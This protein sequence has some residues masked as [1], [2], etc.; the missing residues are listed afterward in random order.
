MD[1][2][3]IGYS[4]MALTGAARAGAMYGAQSVV[5]SKDTAGMRIT[6][7]AAASDIGAITTAVSRTCE[8]QI[9]GTVSV[10]ACT[11]SC[12]GTLRIRVSVT[13]NKTFSL[14]RAFPQLPTTVALSRTAIMRAQ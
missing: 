6:A 10:I 5:L 9:G 11:A 14:L 4:S 1:F 7:Q 3:R 8:C 12:T 2:G 13:A